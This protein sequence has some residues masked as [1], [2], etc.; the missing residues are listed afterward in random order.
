MSNELP[1]FETSQR[2]ARYCHFH[3]EPLAWLFLTCLL[4]NRLSVPAGSLLSKSEEAFHLFSTIKEM[5][6]LDCHRFP[7]H[8]LVVDSFCQ[9]VIERHEQATTKPKPQPHRL[10]Q[11]TE[12]SP[13]LPK[14][15][16]Q[17]PTCISHLLHATSGS[18]SSP[19]PHRKRWSSPSVLT[20]IPSMHHPIPS[21]INASK[22]SAA[23]TSIPY[24]LTLHIFGT[25][26]QLHDPK[27]RFIAKEHNNFIQ[28]LQAAQQGDVLTRH[29]LFVHTFF[30]HEKPSLY[31]HFKILTQF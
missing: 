24:T 17:Q 2:I 29:L 12:P 19:Y 18:P 23:A 3:R 10:R 20:P 1:S 6:W 28:Q 11:S 16:H 27:R 21:H 9:Y 30:E 15:H 26:R 31:I 25:P 13:L 8:P 7:T 5:Y 22:H 14:S 4:A